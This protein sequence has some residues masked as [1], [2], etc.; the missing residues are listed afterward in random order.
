VKLYVVFGHDND[1]YAFRDRAGVGRCEQCTQIID[2]WSE[3]QP[4]SV[5]EPAAIAM[6][7]SSTYDGVDVVSPRFRR[8]IH[9]AG[10]TG[11]TFQEIGDGYAVVRAT[12]RVRFDAEARMTRF[13][14]QCERC[15]SYETVV[16]A[17][18]AFLIPPVDVGPNEFVWTDIEFGSGD[19]K[20]PLLICGENAARALRKAKLKGLDFADVRGL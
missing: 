2:K 16:G 10:L 12:R 4:F 5:D 19:E 13:E 20:S 9:D 6:D 1:R 18:P 11:L 15:G 3:H 17:T 14:N 8:V 7:I